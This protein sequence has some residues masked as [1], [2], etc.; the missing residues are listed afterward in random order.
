MGRSP[1]RNKWICPFEAQDQVCCASQVQLAMDFSR[2]E[3]A[4]EPASIHSC[5]A[6]K[7]FCI[8]C[9]GARI[10]LLVPQLIL[11][12]LL[13]CCTAPSIPLATSQ[14]TCCIHLLQADAKQPPTCP[15]SVQVGVA[16][17]PSGPWGACPSGAFPAAPVPLRTSQHPERSHARGLAPAGQGAQEALSCDLMS[18]PAQSFHGGIS[19]S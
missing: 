9:F 16:S 8:K 1:P 3:Q 2:P 14:P 18:P 7:W 13:H 5:S 4:S 6:S 19:Q 17:P 15:E 10:Q 11:A 12:S